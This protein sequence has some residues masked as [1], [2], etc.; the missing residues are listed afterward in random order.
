[1]KL[2]RQAVNDAYC[3]VCALGG[4]TIPLHMLPS[5]LE[6]RCSNN[7]VFN[8]IELSKLAARVG[9]RETDQPQNKTS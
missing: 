8:T 6:I 1:M 3:P 2:T 5:N 4:L 7:H 9:Q